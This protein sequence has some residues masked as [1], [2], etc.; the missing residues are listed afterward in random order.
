MTLPVC[1]INLA[2]DVLRR[3]RMET[4]LQRIELKG[5]RMEAVR[6]TSLPEPEQRELYSPDLNHRQFHLLMVAG[7]KGCYASHIKAWRMLLES[8]HQALVVLEDD[9]RFDDRLPSVLDAISDL[10][11]PWDMIKLI[12]RDREKVRSRRELI[13]GIDL[14]EYARVPSLTAGYVISRAG[15]QKLLASRVP[16]GRPID[17]DLR[18]WW[19]NDLLVLGVTP[20]M[21]I[22]DET[23][24]V[25]SIGTKSDHGQKHWA[26]RLKK[27]RIKSVLTFRNWQANRRRPLLLD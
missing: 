21:L 12:G 3:V 27:F 9:V 16:F 22:L 19:E 20:S 25:S 10:D 1:Y 2:S 23:S 15:A 13:K 17:V 11:L 18:F 14:V 26:L 8:Q 24:F 7:E 5:Q 6:W 4:E